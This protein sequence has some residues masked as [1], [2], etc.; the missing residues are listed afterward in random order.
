MFRVSRRVV[1]TLVL[2]MVLKIFFHACA[3]L[4]LSLSVARFHRSPRSV[5]AKKAQPGH[6]RSCGEHG[7]SDNR[8]TLIGFLKSVSGKELLSC[9]ENPVDE[10][11]KHLFRPADTVAEEILLS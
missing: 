6:A 1:S 8:S 7:S 9:S 10:W 3:I 11:A 2:N 4:L 5:V